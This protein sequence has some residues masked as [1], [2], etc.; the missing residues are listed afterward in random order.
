MF[1][2]LMLFLCVIFHIV[3]TVMN[4][5]C[6]RPHPSTEEWW[7]GPTN[8]STHTGRW[9]P[10]HIV[11]ISPLQPSSS[12]N[13]DCSC[14]DSLVPVS[15]RLACPISSQVTDHW[16]EPC[17]PTG[18]VHPVDPFHSL[19]NLKNHFASIAFCR[20]SVVYNVR[21]GAVIEWSFV[22]LRGSSSLMGGGRL[23]STLLSFMLS[24]AVLTNEV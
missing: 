17:N 20:N 19:D 14:P 9:Y 16:G 18:E 7:R 23:L 21:N 2:L 11:V 5:C 22:V 4:C 1:A 10:P 3:S 24:I 6:C 12:V 15:S 13:P 8:V